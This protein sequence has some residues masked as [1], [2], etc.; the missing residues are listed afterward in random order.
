M[1][2]REGRGS[3]DYRVDTN[4]ELCVVRWFDNRAVQLSSTHTG[5]EPLTT[6][7][8]WDRRERKYIEVECPRIV[9]EYNEHMGGVDKFDM[10]AALYRI[11][12]KRAKW[13]RRLFLW[14]LSLS[15]I[16]GWLLYKRHCDQN[17]C[18]T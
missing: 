11:D 14:A 6:V 12:H 15:A 9:T 16:N 17:K 2:K 5:I 7:R 4:T 3:Y 18:F 8:R 10:L 13:Y 1:L